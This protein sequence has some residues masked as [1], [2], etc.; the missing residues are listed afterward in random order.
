MQKQ[1]KISIITGLGLI[2][3]MIHF[4]GNLLSSKNQQTFPYAIHMFGLQG[5][6]RQKRKYNLSQRSVFEHQNVKAFYL[7]IYLSN[8]YPYIYLFIPLNQD[9]GNI[10]KLTTRITEILSWRELFFFYVTNIERYLTQSLGEL[11][12]GLLFVYLY[13]TRDK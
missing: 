9:G 6:D 13:H 8:I 4:K 2:F 12:Q 5:T 11:A 10:H 7:F 3:Y 1:K